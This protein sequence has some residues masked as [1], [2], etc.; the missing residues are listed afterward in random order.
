[1]STNSTLENKLTALGAEIGKIVSPY[2]FYFNKTSTVDE[3]GDPCDCEDA[4]QIILDFYIKDNKFIINDDELLDITLCLKTKKLYC[5]NCPAD[6]QEDSK[7]VQEI[8]QLFQDADLDEYEGYISAYLLPWIDP[9]VVKKDF[10][11][12]VGSTIT[13]LREELIKIL[14][15]EGYVFREVFAVDEDHDECYIHPHKTDKILFCFNIVDDRHVSNNGECFDIEYNVD[16]ENIL[17][18]NFPSDFSEEVT[19]EII[20]LF[21]RVDFSP[22][23]NNI[24]V[25]MCPWMIDSVDK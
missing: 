23:K 6:W 25:Y 15:P 17:Y 5:N 8:I 3:D 7:V 4:R 2:G 22:Y 10:E 19:R 1:M 9:K 16:T 13:L 11:N 14:K 21:E 18:N 12:K 20:S 24:S